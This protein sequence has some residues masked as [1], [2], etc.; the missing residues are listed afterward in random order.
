MS[1]YRRLSNLAILVVISISYKCRMLAM[2]VSFCNTITLHRLISVWAYLLS[3]QGYTGLQILHD[4]VQP[5]DLSLFQFVY[6]LTNFDFP[7]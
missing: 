2:G 1:F 4:R 3:Y 6:S 5:F 7:A